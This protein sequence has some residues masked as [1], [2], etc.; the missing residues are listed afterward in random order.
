MTGDW[1]RFWNAA[2]NGAPVPNI[3]VSDSVT[4][5]G[6][7][8]RPTDCC[9]SPDWLVNTVDFIN[10]VISAVCKVAIETKSRL[11]GLLLEVVVDGRLARLL[12]ISL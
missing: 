5:R 2:H 1:N 3:L 10:A 8:A 4:L 12:G 11:A 9:F 6:S 7:P